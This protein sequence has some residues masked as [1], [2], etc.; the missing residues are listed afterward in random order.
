MDMNESIKFSERD[1]FQMKLR[2][3]VITVEGYDCFDCGFSISFKDDVHCDKH[4]YMIKAGTEAGTWY[5]PIRYANKQIIKW[6]C[7]CIDIR[8][9]GDGDGL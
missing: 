5:I 2:G 7:G 8:D 1:I 6:A 4:D 9:I 3:E